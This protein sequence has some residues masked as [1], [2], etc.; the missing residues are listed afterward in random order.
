MIQ[1]G[2]P[3]RTSPPPP[4]GWRSAAQLCY[5]I[6]HGEGI[7]STHR[8]RPMLRRLVAVLSVAV[9]L[10][11]V[12]TASAAV[13]TG[14]PTAIGGGTAT[15]T[16]TVTD[17]APSSTFHF[18]FWW[19]SQPQYVTQTKTEPLPPGSEVRVT[20][21]V[22][23]L[24]ST[25]KEGLDYTYRLVVSEPGNVVTGQPVSFQTTKGSPM[26]LPP[27]PSCR[28]RKVI[29]LR[30]ANAKHALL[31]APACGS[32]HIMVAPQGHHSHAGKNY[33]VVAQ[34]PHAGSLIPWDG[35]ITLRV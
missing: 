28:V 18:E 19:D 13:T 23:D 30:L 33:R 5:R 24:S 10:L 22:E 20:Q 35:S 1:P 11:V 15:L 32:V 8:G 27:R 17:A 16:G 2:S 34:S 31:R 29:G 7:M 4:R 25:S 6:G 9:S 21:K 3:T 14:E 12:A 26:S